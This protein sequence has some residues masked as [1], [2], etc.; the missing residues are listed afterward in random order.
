MASGVGIPFVFGHMFET[1]FF[2]DPAFKVRTQVGLIF[3]VGDYEYW[4][5]GPPRTLGEHVT[6]PWS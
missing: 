3:A 5:P 4:G 1:K 2:V 6:R